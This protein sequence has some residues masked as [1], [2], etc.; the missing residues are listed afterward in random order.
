MATMGKFPIVA[1]RSDSLDSGQA[2][3][4][5]YLHVHEY[6]VVIRRPHGA[7]SLGTT[8]DLID[9]MSKWCIA[10]NFA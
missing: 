2:V 9:V 6:E 7:H 3:H 8:G 5:R 1:H 4:A 10:L